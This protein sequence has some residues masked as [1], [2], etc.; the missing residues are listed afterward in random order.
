MTVAVSQAKHLR[1]KIVACASTGNT[2][3]SLAAYAAHAGM[4]AI[5]FI[6]SGKIALGKLAQAIG[7]GA[8]CIAIHGNF[9]DAMTIVQQLA[10]KSD[11]YLVNSLNPF[12]LEGQK[13]IIWEMLQDMQ[14]QVPDWIVVPGGNLGNTSAFGKALREAKQA[15]WIDRLPRIATIQAEGANPF[16][17][18]YVSGFQHRTTVKAETIATAIQIGNPVNIEKAIEVIQST[19]G[20]VYQVSDTE[21]LEAKGIIDRAGIGCEP[22]SAATLA[23]VKNLVASK[24]IKP[25]DSVC[26]I[27]T[28][29]ILKDPDA[30]LKSNRSN[31]L[32]SLLTE[33]EADLAAIEKLLQ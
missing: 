17:Q 9:D 16:Y 19:S 20:L 10:E 25:D 28:G 32:G 14:W 2:S 29:H 3:A 6:P 22:A 33:V 24:T 23:G 26:C 21:I 12:R 7:Y 18:S 31:D 11:I 1:K 5:V 15:G 4:K 8:Q 30:I 27:L 13:S